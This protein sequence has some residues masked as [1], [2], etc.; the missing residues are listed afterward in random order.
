MYY[1][2]QKDTLV[3]YILWFFLGFFGAHRFYLNHIGVG[4]IYL[5]TFGLFGFGW[6]LDLFLI[7]DLVRRQNMR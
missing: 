6:F 5:F 3:A 7:P 1:G 2:A 4:I